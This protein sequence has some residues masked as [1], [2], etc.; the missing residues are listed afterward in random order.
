MGLLK[1]ISPID[2]IVLDGGYPQSILEEMTEEEE[3][4]TFGLH[5][6]C[7]P[8]R[9]QRGTGLSET[10][11]EYNSHLG[12]FRSMLCCLLYNMKKILANSDVH[13]DHHHS[14]WVMSNFDYPDTHDKS[15]QVEPIHTLPQKAELEASI[16][17][18]QNRFLQS[19][20]DDTYDCLVHID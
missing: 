12:S 19:K 17:E 9:K 15:T 2:C 1:N 10:E 14:L 5:N 18:I 3:Q 20:I 7:L 13:I 16:V 11:A 6:F 8:V 4:D